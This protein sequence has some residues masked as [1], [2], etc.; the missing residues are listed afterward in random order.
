MPKIIMECLGLDITRPYKDLVVSLHQILEKN[1]IMDVIVVDVPPKF[2][3]LLSRSWVAK[4]KGNLQMDLSYT[5]IPIFGTQ[6]SLYKENQLAYMIS[7]RKNLENH[8]IYSVD[9]N[10][11]SSMLFNKIGHEKDE[12]ELEDNGSSESNQR[13]VEAGQGSEPNGVSSMEE[14]NDGWWRMSFDGATRNKGEGVGMW[15]RPHVGDPKFLSY[16]LNF[17]CTNNMVEY[18]V[19][20]LGLK[21]LKDLQA[22]RINIK[23]DSELVI[24][25]VQ[26]SYQAKHP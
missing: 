6:R 15:I 9:T 4:L 11:G 19:L 5:T 25:Q 14:S 7:N 1:L 12:L 17:K 22:Q 10:M 13:H 26:G 21:A 16:K 20:L 18:E 24:N 3:M 23:G 8:P 2:G